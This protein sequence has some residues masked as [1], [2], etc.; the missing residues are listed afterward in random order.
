ML[1]TEA[2]TPPRTTRFLLFFVAL[3]Y[4]ACNFFPTQ[5]GI[6][7]ITHLINIEVQRYQKSSPIIIAGTAIPATKAIPTGA[8]TKVP[9][10]HKSFFFRDQGF[11]PQKVHP[12]G[13]QIKNIDL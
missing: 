11:F 2:T 13:L 6:A 4:L 7:K 9:N 1:L 3:M 12:D 10:C 5:T 8:P